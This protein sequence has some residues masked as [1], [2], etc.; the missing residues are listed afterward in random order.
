MMKNPPH[1]NWQREQEHILLKPPPDS[2]Q[3]APQSMMSPLMRCIVGETLGVKASGGIRSLA[4]L[5]ALVEAGA[6]RI[7]ASAGMAILNEI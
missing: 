4:D 5:L 6:N 3:A 7:G 2:V 1:A